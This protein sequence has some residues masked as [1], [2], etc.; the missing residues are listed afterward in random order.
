MLSEV[1]R[2]LLPVLQKFN[3][4]IEAEVAIDSLQERMQRELLEGGA[5]AISPSLIGA[6]TKLV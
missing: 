2:S 3:I 4:A 6:W 5:I 1:V